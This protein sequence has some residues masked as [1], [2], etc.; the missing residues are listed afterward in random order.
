M[1]ELLS[2]SDRT[3]LRYT[4]RKYEVPYKLVPKKV[5][6]LDGTKFIRKVA[7]I[8]DEHFE[9]LLHKVKN[10]STKNR[11]GECRIFWNNETYK[12]IK[13]IYKRFKGEI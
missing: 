12:T 8:T 5:S 1:Y 10:Q 6:K 2:T 9:E 3:V 7:D 4:L 13:R 11:A